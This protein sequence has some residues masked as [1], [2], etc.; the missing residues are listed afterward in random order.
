VDKSIC[1]AHIADVVHL[2][3]A[4]TIKSPTTTELLASSTPKPSTSDLEDL[5]NPEE[6]AVRALLLGICHRTIE[7]FEPAMQFLQDARKYQ[8]Q[9]NTWV[10]G[11]AMFDLAVLQLK[12]VE[13]R[14]KNQS[15][16]AGSVDW[17][18][19]WLKAI[20]RA[21]ANLDEATLL[22]PN[23]VDLSGRLDSRISMLRDEMASK[24]EMLAKV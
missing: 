24:K 16:E 10:G 15:K 1:R 2:T 14:E 22:S 5:D 21:D 9:V 11:V 18:E 8:T 12:H 7:E 4:L 13:W 3:P 17:K 6:M 23:T 19:E 20:Q